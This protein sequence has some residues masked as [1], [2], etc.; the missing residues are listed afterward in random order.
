MFDVYFFSSEQ[1]KSHYIT[2]SAWAISTVLIQSTYQQIL[3]KIVGLHGRKLLKLIYINNCEKI[4][5]K[6]NKKLK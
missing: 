1:H 4:H 2:I 3:I 5:E 6:I